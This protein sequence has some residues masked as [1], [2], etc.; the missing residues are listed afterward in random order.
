MTSTIN[1]FFGWSR[2]PFADTWQPNPPFLGKKDQRILRRATSLLSYGKSF[3]ITGLSG[4]GK[5]T[6]VQHIIG[7]LDPKHYQTAYIHY[8]GLMR[9]G[10]LR[11]VADCLGV[12]TSGRK[13]PLLV[14]LQKHIFELS[15]QTNARYPVF[16]IDDAQLLEHESLLDLCSL[17]VSP[18]KKTVAASVIL[19]GDETLAKRLCLHTMAPVK[20]RMTCVFAMEGLDEDEVDQFI[21]HRL[22]SASA[23]AD[24][25]GEKTISLIGSHARGN[26]RQLMNI[27]T[28]LLEE[29]FFRQEKTVGAHLVIESDLIDQSG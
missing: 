9:S 23:P 11:A 4:A 29:A 25:F 22:E 8:G 19:V 18:Q 21:N 2:H 15:Q 12:D 6:L 3:A 10:I 7:Q 26:R 1:E 13:I 24:L 5:S 28:L 20:T 27:G 14:K 16:V 17:M